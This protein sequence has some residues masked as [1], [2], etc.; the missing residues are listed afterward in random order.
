MTGEG[1]FVLRADS[2]AAARAFA[3][4][5]PFQAAGVRTYELF[6]WQVNEGGFQLRVRFIDS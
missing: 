4:A 5:E 6:P 1:M 3:D 2:L